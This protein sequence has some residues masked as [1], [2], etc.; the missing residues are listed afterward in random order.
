VQF[1]FGDA[2]RAIGLRAQPASPED[3]VNGAVESVV[4]RPN[5][6][7]PEEENPRPG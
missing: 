1:G 6:R 2:I 5:L 4:V 3:Y 7:T